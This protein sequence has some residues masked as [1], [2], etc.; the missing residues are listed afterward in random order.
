[1]V[2]MGFADASVCLNCRHRI[3]QTN[4]CT[5]CGL[6][7]ATHEIQQAWQA[8]V[9]A[10]QWVERAKSVQ[11]I[12]V[13]AAAR[14]TSSTPTEQAPTHPSTADEPSKLPPT[15]EHPKPRRSL[16]TGS[17]LLGLGALF[18]LVAGSI[19]ISVTWGSLGL[20][21][22]ALVLLAVTVLIG[23]LGSFVT[24][25]GLRASAEALWS[26]FFGLLTLDWFA[27]RNQGLAG[28][29]SW[30]FGVSVTVWAVVVIVA[31]LL[32]VPTG[33]RRLETELWAPSIVA[34]SAAWFAAGSLAAELSD[35]TAADTEFWPA[36]L[37]T[38]VAAVAGLVL[39]RASVRI[40]SWISF[41]GAAFF[42]L[43]AVGFAIAEAVEHPSLTELVVDAHGLPL[44]LMVV[45][46]IGVGVL[47]E[48]ARLA[49][50]AAALAGVATLILLP[51]EEAWP[52]RGAFV[53]GAGLLAAAA[54]SFTG[55]G[56]WFQGARVT[57]AVGGCVLAL[58]TMPWFGKLLAVV[59]EGASASRTDELSTPL[60]PDFAPETGAWWVAAL[61]T[62]GLSAVILGAR[63]WPE[64]DDVR[65]HL[66]AVATCLAVVGAWAVLATFDPAALL[67]GGSLVAGGALLALV[68]PGS[69]W[70]RWV[71]PTV[72]A[73]APLSTLS[74][75]PAA[76]IIWPVVGLVLAIVAART[77]DV[78]LRCAAAF[79]AAG[80][81]LGTV[82]PA[83]ELVDGDDRWTALALVVAA[84][85]GLTVSLFALRE[86][87]AHL[88]AEV[89]SAGL[90]VLGL[91]I[92]GSVS[93]LGFASFLCT[94]AGAGVA[95][96]GL[97]S[98]RRTWY[99]WVGSGL[100]GVAYVLRLAA[101]D[102]DVVEAYTLPFAAFL[103]IVGLWTMRKEPDVGSV[104]ALLPGVALALLPSLPEALD[105]PTGLRALLLGAGAAIALAVGTWRRWQVPFVAGAIVLALIVLVN[106]GP[107]AL[108]LPRWVLIASAGALLLAAGITWDDRVRD[109]RAAIRYVGSMR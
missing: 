24:R 75:W 73:L 40:G 61:V 5:N 17:V 38:A 26:V 63:R 51:V 108:A 20:L 54:W 9:V 81:G 57:V 60:V 15:A 105:E 97:T 8:L 109:G 72:V 3:E 28:L 92:G 33:R 1:M 43:F 99:R 80:W 89:S 6:D 104:R 74:S 64:T 23:G 41:A 96:L 65:A 88:G 84:L 77:G 67:L 103:L 87:M 98:S 25:R 42:G 49:A 83:F 94:V 48:P 62:L 50:S 91:T 56:R 11:G 78:A 102:V 106:V 85:V 71:G 36:V 68:L 31:A 14:A 16:S 86:D 82:V 37:A 76:V 34:G 39:R 12:G 2:A 47:V 58:A 29:D 19:F 100:L 90:G 27:A 46:T 107:P 70:W 13:T 93:T 101:S 45:A 59:A 52:E 10:D 44:L 32:V 95:V 4:R 35:E 22:R 55:A 7:L 53:L 79:A 21:G 69:T 30:P 18:I 66:P